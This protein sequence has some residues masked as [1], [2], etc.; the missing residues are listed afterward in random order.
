[1]RIL[2]TTEGTYP[3]VMGGVSTWVDQLIRGMEEHSFRVL[4]VSGPRPVNVVFPLPTNVEQVDTLHLWTPRGG[5]ALRHEGGHA[6]FDGALEALLGFADDDL[7]AF[8]HGL[9][10]LAR[11]GDRRNLWPAFERKATWAL[12]T[13]AMARLRGEPPRLAEV[14]L[15]IAWLRGTLV[16]L[17]SIPPRTDQA[18]TTS[19]GLSAI[20]AWLAAQEHG[21]PLMLTEHGLYLRERYLSFESERTPPAVKLLRGRFY[22]A[23]AQRIYG[24]ADLVVSVSE[25]N[26]SWQVQLGAP[27][28]RT[29]VVYNGVDPS[30][31]PDAGRLPLPDPTVSWV[32]RIDPIKDLETL[33]SAFRRV[34]DHLASA[35]LR[36]FGPVP[37]GNERYAEKVLALVSRLRLQDA[38]AFEGSISPIY[39]AYHGAD[40]VALSSVSE[41]FPYVAIEAMMCGRPVV[42]TRVGGVAEAV[43]RFGAMVTPRSPEAFGDALTELLVDPSRRAHL[44]AGARDRAL[45]R[46]TLARMYD[47][48]R[49]LYG[50]LAD[51]SAEAAA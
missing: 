2:L 37:K 32:G 33:V 50:E 51:A 44:G 18:H 25:F 46:F 43:D 10:T 14:A 19:N 42:A 16:P 36:L 26:R 20:P 24:D 21:I 49:G 39:R 23:L 34:R 11:L 6:A 47:G 38:I 35:R 17:L 22:R 3:S 30:G 13:E 45:S 28:E 29:R 9:R 15:A 27:V 31:F 1:V 5:A 41:G 7:D 48:Y 4:E 12:I 8:A 40:V